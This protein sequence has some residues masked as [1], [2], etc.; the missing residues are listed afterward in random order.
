MR[1]TVGDRIRSVGRLGRAFDPVALGEARSLVGRYMEVVRAGG[2]P[3]KARDG[4]RVAVGLKPVRSQ[5]ASADSGPMTFR[6]VTR[7]FLADRGGHWKSD[8]TEIHFSKQM[9]DYAYPIIG[10]LRIDK[11][12]ITDVVEVLRGHPGAPGEE[13]HGRGLPAQRSPWAAHAGDAAVGRLPDRT[14]HQHRQVS[15]NVADLGGC[16]L[17]VL[18][19]LISPISPPGFDRRCHARSG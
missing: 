15:A 6:Q 12:A 9:R 1:W 11:I 13:R 19:V 4:E 5:T 2:D 7:A 10:D 3:R 17:P 8:T 16:A 18:K 14:P